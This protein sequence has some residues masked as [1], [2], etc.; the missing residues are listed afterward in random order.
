MLR[1]RVRIDA[2]AE[3][4]KVPAGKTARS[5]AQRFLPHLLT[6]GAV[7][8]LLFGIDVLTGDGWW[9][10]WPLLGWGIGVSVHAL[11]VYGRGGV[12]GDEWEEKKIRELM[13]KE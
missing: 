6:Y 2:R 8:V 10:Y 3:R 1:K 4:R 5:G 11:N 13:D 9:F 7:M 12:F